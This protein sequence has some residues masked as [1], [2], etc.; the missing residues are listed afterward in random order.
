VGARLVRLQTTPLAPG[1]HED[2]LR[3][4][5]SVPPARSVGV[6]TRVLGDL[7]TGQGGRQGGVAHHQSRPHVVRGGRRGERAGDPG[8][9]DDAGHA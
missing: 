2:N 1:R 9:G 6:P 5:A 8:D 4:P 7:G 3:T